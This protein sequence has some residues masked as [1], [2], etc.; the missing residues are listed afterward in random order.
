MGK[1]FVFGIGGTGARVLRSLIFLLGS[2]V[3]CNA[4][5]VVPILI[6]P[7]SS[8]G[9]MNRTLDLMSIYKNIN[10]TLS[11]KE[12]GFFATPILSLSSLKSE[13]NKSSTFQFHLEK[14]QNTNFRDYISYHSL[15]EG[16]KY[17]IDL[18]FSE[19]NLNMEMQVG[20][21]GNPNVGSVVLNQFKNS[22]DFK[23]F[24]NNFSKG[25]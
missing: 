25:E 12:N 2:G 23:I 24:A 13:T 20:F 21:R 9:D 6:D 17:L 15:G 19:A 11:K 1:V 7:D 5:A 8:N 10:Q 18:L 14:I 22:E 3:K 16:N 4:S